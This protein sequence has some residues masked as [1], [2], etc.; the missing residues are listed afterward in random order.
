MTLAF[1]AQERNIRI[2]VEKINNNEKDEVLKWKISSFF[3]IL[4][5]KIIKNDKIN[6]ISIFKLYNNIRK[7]IDNENINNRR[8]I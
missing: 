3:N 5:T 8:W 7:E 2:V 6:N 1:A 4:L